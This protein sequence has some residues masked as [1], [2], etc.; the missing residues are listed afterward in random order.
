MFAYIYFLQKIRK[1]VTNG[2]VDECSTDE[3]VTMG[4]IDIS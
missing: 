3:F 4:Y 1:Q 2:R